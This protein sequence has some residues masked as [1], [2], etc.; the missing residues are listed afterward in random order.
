MNRTQR[1]IVPP[2]FGQL[3]GDRSLI[4]TAQEIIDTI[5]SQSTPC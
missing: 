4:Q 2:F 3:K 1:Q 5:A